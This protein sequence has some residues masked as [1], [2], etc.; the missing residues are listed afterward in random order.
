MTASAQ[1]A[2]QAIKEL[3][4]RV[5]AMGDYNAEFEVRAEG[6]TLRGAY[7]VS[8]S[9]FW[10]HTAAY[11]AMS[12]GISRWEVNH[13][14]KEVL[15]DRVDPADGNVLANPTRAFEFAPGEFSAV[16]RNG[17]IV[18]TPR[19]EHNAMQAITLVLNHST[20]LPDEVRYRQD[21]L[22]EEI[23]VKIRKIAKGL[24]SGTTFSFDRSKYKGYE[25]VD[26]R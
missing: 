20:G 12:D 9:R 22:R 8:G 11:D 18:L 5:K 26:F 19:N 6:R 3:G 2:S 15:I 4:A 17:E 16:S 21:G 24:P 14:D 13:G 7:A 10:M 1:D 25:E 23:I